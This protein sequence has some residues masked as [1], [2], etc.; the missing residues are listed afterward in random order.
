MKNNLDNLRHSCAHLL[1]AAIMELYPHAKR[2]IGPAIENGF[3]FDFDLKDSKISE[4]DFPK[5]EQKMH[6][7]VKEW[8]N[9]VRH[10]LTT[11]E[12]KKEFADN[13]YKQELIEEFAK[14]GEKI[15]FYKSGNYWDLCAGGHCENP[16]EEL[17]HFKLLS[18]AGAYWR[19][20]E[21]NKMLTRI[22]GTVFPTKEELDNH[23]KMLEEAKK[24]DH[25]KLG[26]ELKLFFIDDMVGKGLVM[27]LPNGFIV[28]EQIEN[29]AK[30]KEK[31]A[32][33]VRVATP[34]IAREELFITSGH[35]PYY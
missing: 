4:E 3:Y 27:W 16:K 15:S 23:L 26:K 6:E 8:E 35:H 31:E 19:G 13:P 17:K 33:Y 34:H 18:T 24:R 32:G 7:I 5:I 30:Q 28:R 11:E 20:S 12:A 1:A 25:R 10:E 29:L 22:Y 2:T 21:K 9:F 14:N